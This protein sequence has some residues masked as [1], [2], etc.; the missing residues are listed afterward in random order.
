MPRRRGVIKKTALATITVPAF[1]C[2]KLPREGDPAKPPEDQDRPCWQNI[3]D[4]RIELEPFFDPGREDEM[5]LSEEEMH[6]VYDKYDDENYPE[7]KAYLDTVDNSVTVLFNAYVHH[8]V[9]GA[10][11]RYN[12]NKE[13]Y[14]DPDYLHRIRR[15]SHKTRRGRSRRDYHKSIQRS[16]TRH[17]LRTR[18]STR[19]P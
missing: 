15:P 1:G 8:T 10:K 12:E 7:Y 17:Q 3:Q 5:V 18:R 2:I 4:E 19:R 11:T 14:E 6:S 13:S 16:R 9:D